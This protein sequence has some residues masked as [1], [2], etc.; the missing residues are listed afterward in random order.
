MS[1]CQIKDPNAHDEK[2]SMSDIMLER[3]PDR[4]GPGEP[5]VGNLGSGSDY[6]WFYQ[7]IGVSS[8]DLGHRFGYKNRTRSY[9]V[10]HSQHDTYNWVKRFADPQFLFHKA[11]SQ[12]GGAILLDY[13][14]S[15]L[16]PMS[17]S[18][19]A[20][21]LN[22]SLKQFQRHYSAKFKSQNIS[23]GVLDEAVAKFSKASKDFEARLAA[24]K[25]KED[26]KFYVLRQLNDQ[27]MFLERA[28]I[29]PYGLPG[30]NL[31]RH[32]IFAPDSHN[33][34]G[35]ASFP[36]ITDVLFDVEKTGN[37][38]EVEKQISVVATCV[39]SAADVLAPLTSKN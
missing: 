13:T 8:L 31:V 7:H 1:I 35:S 22:S 34:Y 4:L 14:D 12:L 32:V 28:F 38:A 33:T 26:A 17:V 19:Y 3:V 23:T 29:N 6:A 25:E 16:L 21:A 2:E 10:Y 18:R 5:Y 30:R 24:V 27:M 9:P 37:W 36:G 39:L 20:L 11:M 15:P